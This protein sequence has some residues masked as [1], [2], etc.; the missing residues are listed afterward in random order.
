MKRRSNR[1]IAAGAAI[2]PRASAEYLDGSRIR[3]TWPCGHRR[4]VDFSKRPLAKR[5]GPE[6][7]RL[8]ARWWSGAG[9]GVNA[10]P[11]PT[12]VRKTQP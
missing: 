8:M 11:C 9:G 2:H 7:S 6:G 5:M 3:F 1:T 4:T 12:C 10:G